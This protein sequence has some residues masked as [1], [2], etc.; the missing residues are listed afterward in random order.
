MNVWIKKTRKRVK[1]FYCEKFIEVGEYQVVC[2]YFMPLFKSERVWTKQ[3]HFHAQNPNCWLDRAI[4]ELARRPY[5]E[6]RG[7]KCDTISDNNKIERLR[8]LRQRS[9]IMHRIKVEM[10][11]R[12]DPKRLAHLCELLEKKNTEIEPY[13]G[14]PASWI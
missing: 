8:I 13:G 10:D 3:M 12:G 11:T 4:S 6:K 7:R 5:V 1:C 9:S 2:S 14:I